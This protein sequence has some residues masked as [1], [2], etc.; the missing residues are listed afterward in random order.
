MDPNVKPLLS[1]QHRLPI[2]KKKSKSSK[3]GSKPT[4]EKVHK[5]IIKEFKAVG[6]LALPQIIAIEK[7]SSLIDQSIENQPLLNVEFEP[8]VFKPLNE[9]E[10]ESKAKV[11][12][13]RIAN[14]SKVKNRKIS[15]QAKVNRLKPINPKLHN[16]KKN[17]HGGK[18]HMKKSKSDQEE[19]TNQ[20]PDT[21]D[22]PL[23]IPELE[24]FLNNENLVYQTEDTKIYLL[25]DTINL[26]Q[27]QGVLTGEQAEYV[28]NRSWNIEQELENR[29]INELLKN[30]TSRLQ[31]LEQ[32]LT[33][34]N[35]KNDEG[36]LDDIISRLQTLEI[37]ASLIK[38]L[39]EM[40][41][42]FQSIELVFS[43]LD[44]RA[45]A[46]DLVSLT[47]RLQVIENDL[48]DLNIQTKYDDLLANLVS[49]LQV[50]E[51]DLADL[52]IQT[53][54]DDLLANLVSRLQIIENSIADLVKQEEE[55]QTI[56]SDTPIIT[57]RSPV[58]L[59]K[60][61]PTIITDN[62]TDSIPNNAAAYYFVQQD[63]RPQST[64]IIENGDTGTK[65]YNPE[66]DNS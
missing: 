3:P 57:S 55:D 63:E 45:K 53:K 21:S 47:S 62:Q 16:N 20:I 46:E 52:N 40:I 42:H 22:P 19:I 65:P 59:W 50:I 12:D 29:K 60:H 6:N 24:Q 31:A 66:T 9:I 11:I 18:K 33:E 10:L 34:M 4:E 41:Y 17:Q 15:S 43:E 25:P 64:K 49:R 1:A 51:N 58:A 23:D 38:P 35:R 61:R 37:K 7:P 13:T 36:L 54:Y 14:S 48:T 32:E 30:L 5:S 44:K 28:K 26:D 2:G 39:E 27:I 56:P 8:I